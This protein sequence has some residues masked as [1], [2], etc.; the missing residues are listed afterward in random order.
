[1]LKFSFWQRVFALCLLLVLAACG[2]AA[3]SSASAP[4]G[5]I[6]ATP[7]NG[8]VTISWQADAGVQYWLMYAPTTTAI[9]IKN[10]PAGHIWASNISSP[11]VIS[12]L[13]N[14]VTY[15]F[16]M[17]GRTG[18]GPGG[19]QTASVSA[20]P[21]AAGSS[22]IA[23]TTT[24]G[25]G[26]L[27]GVALGTAS[28]ATVNY[29][30]VGANGAMYKGPEGVSQGLTGMVWSALTPLANIN[31]HAASYAFSKFIAVGAASNG[32]S[33][34]VYYSSDMASW[35]GVATT[36]STG[37]NALASNGTTLLAV[38]DGGKA[39]SSTDGI[40]WNV[41]NTG[42]GSNLYG[43]AYSS[44]AGW[45]V[46]GAGGTLLTSTDLLS[47]HSPT[48]GAVSVDLR[49][50][51]VTSGNVLVAVGAGGTVLRS[52]DGAAWTSQTLASSNL[53]AVSTD[54]VQFLAVGASGGIFS[55]L[56]GVSWT[57]VSQNANAND[58]LA[59]VGTASKY[60]VVGKAGANISSIN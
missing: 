36:G 17:N 7:G 39:F 1:M 42:V 21:R 41:V 23:G 57:A 12:G 51:A 53:Y 24:L 26:D 22:W 27:N 55:S 14:G 44:L 13:T 52:S 25:T 18:G 28:D 32:A 58:L 19:A 43:V 35:T 37:L 6:T 30:A 54:S 11:Y 48:S 49:G 50:V 31:F 5:G 9:D 4:T 46:V 3:G 16:A 56:D 15:S 60:M 45:V 40:S 20:V 29:L 33:S 34:N 8:Q 38:G 10:P 2:G 47:W 59:V